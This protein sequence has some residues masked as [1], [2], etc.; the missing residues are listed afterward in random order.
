[1]QEL[2]VNI[3]LYLFEKHFEAFQKFV[4]EQSNVKFV[5][6]ASHPYT[7]EQEGYKYKIYRI[8]RD[9]LAFQAWKKEDIGS[10]EI[11][12][13]TI[14]SIEFKE[15]NLVQWQSRYGDEKRPH[16]PLF[17]AQDS[18]IKTKR[19]EAVLFNLYH[20]T[21]SEDSFN[22]L[23]DIFGKKYALLA[24]LYFVKD[25]SKYLPIAPLYF[26]K[27]FQLLGVD[28]KTS[29]R[30]SWENYSLYI[31][32]IGNTKNLLAEGLSSE[33]SLLDAHSFAWML[34]A[35]MDENELADVSDYLKLSDTER[36]SIIKSRIGQGQFRQSLINYWSACAVTGCKEQE[37]LRASHIKPWSKSTA[38]ERLSLYNGL[39]LSPSL[40]LCFDSGFISF[41]SSG[42]II[43][44]NQL[45]SNDLE[46][47]SINKSMKLSNISQEHEKYLEYHR[48]HIYQANK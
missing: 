15:N 14:D 30:C 21:S 37:L 9:K 41:N 5:S 36:N 17:E 33:V 28:F 12:S 3:D 16:Q 18:A 27:T 24:Y 45:S 20:E 34:S 40:D 13:A 4:E 43:I 29:Q 23:L 48:K 19:I 6:F 2:T 1:M 31:D 22:D 25:S 44:S 11:I 8:A 32:L 47:L 39:L 35:Q 10:G 42:E 38:T 46:A 7:D 26:D